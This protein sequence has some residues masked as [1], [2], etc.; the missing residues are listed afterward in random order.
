MQDAILRLEQFLVEFVPIMARNSKGNVFAVLGREPSAA[1]EPAD[2]IEFSLQDSAYFTVVCPCNVPLDDR[3]VPHAMDVAL[4]LNTALTRGAY[5]VKGN[6]WS[7]RCE[8]FSMKDDAEFRHHLGE[9]IRHTTT[10]YEIFQQALSDY[11]AAQAHGADS[12]D[13]WD[14]DKAESYQDPLLKELF[15]RSQEE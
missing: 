1:F 4:T 10:C 11:L 2:H 12:P 3:L 8:L 14:T 7:H 6:F 5:V 9:T 15:D 13:G